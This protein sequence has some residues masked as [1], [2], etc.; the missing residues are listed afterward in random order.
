MESQVWVNFSVLTRE[1]RAS[2]SHSNDRANVGGRSPIAIGS[3]FIPAFDRSVRSLGSTPSIPNCASIIFNVPRCVR[4]RA[5]SQTTSLSRS[6]GNSRLT[7]DASLRTPSRP[8]SRAPFKSLRPVLTPSNAEFSLMV[9]QVVRGE[10]RRTPSGIFSVPGACIC[11]I[12]STPGRTTSSSHEFGMA[13]IARPHQRARPSLNAGKWA[14]R[15]PSRRSR[16]K[17][18]PRCRHCS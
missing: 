15:S 6:A 4:T 5:P 9:C 1:L 3:S 8:T 7:R 13:L 14:S 16:S 10:F 11:T 17:G 12:Q 18:T 2:A